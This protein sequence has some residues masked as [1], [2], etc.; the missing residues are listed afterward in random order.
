MKVGASSFVVDLGDGHALVV[1]PPRDPRA[2][3]AAAGHH[4]LRIGFAADT[5]LH[6]ISSPALCPSP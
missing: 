3:H 4:G 2:V 1:D 6:A 5:H